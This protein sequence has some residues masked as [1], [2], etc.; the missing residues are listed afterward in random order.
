MRKKSWSRNYFWDN[1]VK[2]QLQVHAL[3]KTKE[4]WRSVKFWPSYSKL[5]LVNFLG[6][7]CIY[8]TA[9]QMVNKTL[10]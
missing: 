4:F 6:T 9:S 2:E 10:A 7:Q 1:S 8:H 5:N 3:S